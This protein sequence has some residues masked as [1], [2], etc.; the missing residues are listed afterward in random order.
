M[1]Y[2]VTVS[3]QLVLFHPSVSVLPPNFNQIVATSRRESLNRIASLVLTDAIEAAF[4]RRT[5]AHGVAA[6]SV[7]VRNLSYV[8]R[9][10]VVNQDGYGAVRAAARQNQSVLVR[11]PS[12]G[13]DRRIMARVLV[14]FCPFAEFLPDYNLSEKGKKK[15][16]C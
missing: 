6:D 8:P 16:I 13:V 10:S 15:C 9:V 12:N 1:A 4:N 7:G 2:P 5:P 14:N 3:F 11:R